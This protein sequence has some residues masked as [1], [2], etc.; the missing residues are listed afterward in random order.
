MSDSRSIGMTAR[1]LRAV[2]P[3]CHFLLAWQCAG[4]G[5]TDALVPH[6]LLLIERQ[7]REQSTEH[8]SKQIQPPCQDQK[9]F[10]LF[11]HCHARK[12]NAFL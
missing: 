1:C 11:V 5:A 9:S 7:T 2:C 3:A 10:A 8:V 12:L 6:L 4:A